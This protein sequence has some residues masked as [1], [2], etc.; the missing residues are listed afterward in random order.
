MATKLEYDT[1]SKIMGHPIILDPYNEDHIT[2]VGSGHKNWYYKKVFDY[3][4]TKINSK[5]RTL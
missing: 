4:M 1:V 2:E 5:W 3:T